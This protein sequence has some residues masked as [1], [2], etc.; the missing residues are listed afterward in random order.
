M[1]SACHV[2]CGTR[3]SRLFAPDPSP[4]EGPRTLPTIRRCSWCHLACGE[5]TTKTVFYFRRRLKLGCRLLIRP[6][7]D[8]CWRSFPRRF[9]SY[10]N[11]TNTSELDGAAVFHNLFNNRNRTAW[12]QITFGSLM[13]FLVFFLG[14]YSLKLQYRFKNKVD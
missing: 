6:L 5:H 2:L 4:P 10:A 13:R 8:S 1:S 12:G 3:T 9:I 14:Q 7:I 11:N